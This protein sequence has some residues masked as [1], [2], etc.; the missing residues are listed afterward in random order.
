MDEPVKID[1]ETARLI[2][3]LLTRL[4][5]LMEDA[6]TAAL[7]QES[8]GGSLSERVKI[9]QAEVTGM[10]SIAEAASALLNG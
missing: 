10:K 6:S 8:R 5:M 3:E 4:G 1:A 2:N 9:L 7:L